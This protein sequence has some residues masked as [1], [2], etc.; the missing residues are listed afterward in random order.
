MLDQQKAEK[1]HVIGLR[2]MNAEPL[3]HNPEMDMKRAVGRRGWVRMLCMI[4]AAL[5]TFAPGLYDI[6]TP[7]RS[8]DREREQFSSPWE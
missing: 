7:R 3:I 4:A 1:Q 5:R 8:V 6:E 2:T